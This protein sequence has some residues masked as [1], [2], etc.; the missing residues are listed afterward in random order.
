MYLIDYVDSQKWANTEGKKIDYT[1]ILFRVLEAIALTEGKYC[2]D[3]HKHKESSFL[4]SLRSSPKDAES[5][6]AVREECFLKC[7]ED[8]NA[9]HLSKI[10]RL[11]F[12]EF[13]FRGNRNESYVENV[14]TAIRNAKESIAEEVKTKFGRNAD[15]EYTNFDKNLFNNKRTAEADVVH[16]AT[17]KKR[18]AEAVVVPLQVSGNDNQHA[19]EA[20]VVPLQV[21][22]NDNQHAAEAGAVISPVY[23]ARIDLAAEAVV[24]PL[25]VP[26]N[27]NQHAT[28]AVVVPLEVPGNDNQHAADAVISP[29]YRGRI[30]LAAEADMDCEEVEPNASSDL[31]GYRQQSEETPCLARFVEALEYFFH[32]PSRHPQKTN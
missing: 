9:D 11:M 21:S 14:E 29:V 24:A 10:F 3:E 18:T 26:G 4:L 7:H 1:E 13:S 2:V 19:A 6:H 30:D 20:V 23:G 28:E 25:Q 15:E 16:P 27:D 5:T 12:C 31:G 32:Q 8:K 17:K 22:G